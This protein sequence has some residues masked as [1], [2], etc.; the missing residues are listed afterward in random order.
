VS[1]IHDTGPADGIVAAA[2]GVTKDYRMPGGVVHA[3][4][5]VTLR[6]ARG[7]LVSVVGPSGCGKST[8]LHLLGGVDRP[9]SGVVRLLGRGTGSMGDAALAGLRLRHVGFVFQRFFLLPMLTA[10][11]NV[12]LP[13][14]AAGVPAAARRARASRLLE[15]VGLAHRARHRPGQLSGGEMQRV[16]IARALANQPDVILADEP[17]GELDAATGAEIVRLLH[18]ISR[19][20]CA[21]VLVT[22]NAE[23]ASL[24]DRQIR[25]RD[26]LVLSEST[27]TPGGHP[28]PPSST[29]PSASHCESPG[30]SRVDPIPPES[31]ARSVSRPE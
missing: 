27:G 3:L 5:G 26:G 24:A 28:T 4:R 15:R 1:A 2:E 29:V 17:T 6:V 13:M 12:L 20:G 19:D 23:L 7:V 30:A 25:M 14:M 18:A 9:T 10:E 8:L 31:T 21:V 11:E 22:H 16:A